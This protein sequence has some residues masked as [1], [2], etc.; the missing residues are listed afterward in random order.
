MATNEMK[1]K[2][3]LF[4]VFLFILVTNE[5]SYKI[6]NSI[7]GKIIGKTIEESGK[8]TTNG[9]IL[10]VLI[11]LILVRYSMDLNLFK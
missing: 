4:S 1:W 10:H 5:E 7:V 9:Y 2:I 3:S 6:T 11:F 8:I